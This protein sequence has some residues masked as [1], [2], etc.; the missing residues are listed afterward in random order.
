MKV[1][2]KKIVSKTGKKKEM[3]SID[4]REIEGMEVLFRDHPEKGNFVLDGSLMAELCRCVADSDL[5]EA[6]SNFKCMLKD[7]A[8]FA[9]K[10]EVIDEVHFVVSPAGLEIV[11]VTNRGHYD[12]DL[13][14]KMID[15]EFSFVE[16]YGFSHFEIRQAPVVLLDENSNSCNHFQLYGRKKSTSDA[17]A[18]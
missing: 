12:F 4:L 7:T 13:S 2:I 9:E 3:P 14:E 15:L 10:N 17:V 11:L 18:S 5:Q 16:L 6:L 8:V 1:E